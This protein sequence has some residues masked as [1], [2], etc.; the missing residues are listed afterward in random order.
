[1]SNLQS[2]W[3]LSRYEPVCSSAAKP[4]TGQSADSAP[5]RD[6]VV[7]DALRTVPLPS[8]FL[9]RMRGLVSKMSDESAD[10]VDYLGC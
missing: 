2:S 8:G 6:E 1:M 5:S 9:M 3:A 4:E 10:Q 7:D